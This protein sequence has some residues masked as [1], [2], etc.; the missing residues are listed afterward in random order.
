MY[1][2]DWGSPNAERISPLPAPFDQ[3]LGAHHALEIP[4]VLGNIKYWLDPAL[5]ATTFNADNRESR[6]NLSA[7]IVDYC[8]NFA[9]SGDPNDADLTNWPAWSNTEDS[10]KAIVFDT[11]PA[12]QSALISEDT[13][14]WTFASVR[15]DI[16]SNVAEPLRTELLTKLQSL[17]WLTGSPS[18][19]TIA[20]KRVPERY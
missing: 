5:S 7:A 13:Q 18:G 3:T 1:R 15:A 10:A 4:F 8:G 2:F 17:G 16:D 12:D 19:A 20:S 9:R 6:V 14:A 11:N